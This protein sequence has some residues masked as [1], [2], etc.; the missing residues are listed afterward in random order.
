MIK[1]RPMSKSLVILTTHFGTNFSGGSTATHE[2]FVRLQNE[3]HQIA[4]VCNKIG[5]HR[6][7][8]AEFKLYNSSLEAYKILRS[9]SNE[10][11]IFY[12]DFYNSILFVW[13]K[14]KFYFTYHDN[15][16]EMKKTSLYNYFRS[17]FYIPIY[18][19]ILKGSYKSINM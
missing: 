19:N 1:D 2:I 18:K 14:K 13:A 6:F 7:R 5:H 15:W 10:D 8:K 16:P 4:V 11:T 12:G 17:V 3:F 9:L